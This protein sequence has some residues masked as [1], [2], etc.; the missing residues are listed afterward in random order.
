[1]TVIPKSSGLFEVAVLVSVAEAVCDCYYSR[2]L[3]A[4]ASIKWGTQG[5][6]ERLVGVLGRIRGQGCEI[7]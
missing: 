4:C 2:V 7:A 3:K 1:M 6:S 5:T